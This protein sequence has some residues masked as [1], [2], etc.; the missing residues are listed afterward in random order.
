MPRRQ[1]I[2][3]GLNSVPPYYWSSPRWDLFPG[4]PMAVALSSTIPVSRSTLVASS[5]PGPIQAPRRAPI[6][7]QA[8]TAWWSLSM[9]LVQVFVHAGPGSSR[10]LPPALL[11]PSSLCDSSSCDVPFKKHEL[12]RIRAS[13]GCIVR[14]KLHFCRCC[15]ATC[16]PIRRT[17]GATLERYVPSDDICAAGTSVI[18]GLFTRDVKL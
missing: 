10:T 7:R 16:I 9:S 15:W 11:R 5:T 17:F 6:D 3:C 4:T 12:Q 2:H 1:T 18:R 14:T 8:R 13:R